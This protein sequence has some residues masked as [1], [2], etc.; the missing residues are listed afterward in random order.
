MLYEVIT[1]HGT[2][3]G[4]A[5]LMPGDSVP[6]V[7]LDGQGRHDNPTLSPDGKWV[8]FVAKIID[9]TK[10]VS[11]GPGM[12]A[13]QSALFSRYRVFKVPADGGKPIQLSGLLP[14]EEPDEDIWPTWS[15][16]GKWS[17]NFV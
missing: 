1:I 6:T 8:A 16:D 15:P 10:T 2:P 4:L 13:K 17:Y 14:S 5:V 11:V 12:T 9:M 7:I 3:T